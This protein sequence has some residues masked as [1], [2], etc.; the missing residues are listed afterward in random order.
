[1]TE[2]KQKVWC[3]YCGEHNSVTVI[4]KQ[5]KHSR[6]VKITNCEKCKKQNGVYEVLTRNLKS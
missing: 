4:T 1:M 3:S 6:S 2:I 5:T